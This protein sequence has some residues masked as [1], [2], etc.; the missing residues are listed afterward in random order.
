[1]KFKGNK[2]IFANKTRADI[3]LENDFRK[4]LGKDFINILSEEKAE[5]YF[6]GRIIRTF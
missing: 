3:I 2:L 5:G 1:M 6:H 4:F